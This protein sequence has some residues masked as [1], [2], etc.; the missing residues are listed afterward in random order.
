MGTRGLLLVRDNR[1]RNGEWRGAQPVITTIT[2]M[3]AMATVMMWLVTAMSAP[4]RNTSDRIHAC[5]CSSLPA[6]FEVLV[7][8]TRPRTMI[9]AN[10]SLPG[11]RVGFLD[12]RVANAICR[13]KHQRTT[14]AR[15]EWL[16]VLR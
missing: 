2:A 9:T 3:L 11:Q 16:N 12:V 13:S 6:R 14:L 4:M 15:G 10:G 1:R 5:G 7:S 8:P